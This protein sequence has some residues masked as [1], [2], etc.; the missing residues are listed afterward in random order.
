V[1]ELVPGWFIGTNIANREK[2]QILDRA[3]EA[4]GITS[5]KDLRIELPNPGGSR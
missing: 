3:C 4:A 1:V 5:G 2:V